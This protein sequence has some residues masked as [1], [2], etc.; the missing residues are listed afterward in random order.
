METWIGMTRR[1]E[2]LPCSRSFGRNPRTTEDCRSVAV[3]WKRS[4]VRSVGRLGSGR[5]SGSDAERDI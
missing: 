2:R 4:T 3:G 1:H 5:R